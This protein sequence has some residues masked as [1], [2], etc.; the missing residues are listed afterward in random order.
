MK[1]D[2]QKPECGQCLRAGRSCRIIDG[3]FRPHSYSFLVSSSSSSSQRA[4]EASC[5]E[6]HFPGDPE[7]DNPQNRT[8][9]SHQT[10]EPVV[11][12]PSYRGQRARTDSPKSRHYQDEPVPEC[13]VSSTLEAH[14]VRTP[15]E[16]GTT[17]MVELP[18]PDTLEPLAVPGPPAILSA[19]IQNEPDVAIVAPIAHGFSS[20][21]NSTHEDNRRDRCEVAFFLR[22]FSEGPGQWM[23]VCCDHP[24]FS[25]QVPLLSPV[26]TL[27]RYSAVAL[28]A[29]QLGYM[30]SPESSIRQTQS[31]RLMMQAFAGSNLDFLWYGAK[32]YDKAIQI[33]SKLLSR[34]DQ[35]VCQ[36]SPRGSYQAGLPTPESNE[37]NLAAEYDNTGTTLQIIAACILCQYEDLSATMKAWSSHLDGTYRLLRSYL[38]ETATPP[39]ALPIP[40]PMKAMDAIY[41]FFAINDMLD[42]FVNK[43]RT[44]LESKDFS[45]WRKMGLPLDEDGKLMA[46]YVQEVHSESIFFKYLIWLMCQLV[47]SDLGNAVE[48]NAINE[49][50]DHWQ[51]ILPAIFSSAIHWPPFSETDDAQDP[52][53]IKITSHETWFPKDA[54]ALSMAFY[55]MARILL[56]IHRPLEA[57]RQKV[58][59]GADLLTTYHSLQHDLRGHAIEIISIARGAPNGTVR[60]YLIQPLYV[61]GRCLEDANERQELLSILRQIDEDLGVFTDYRQED[62]SLEWGIPYH[63]IEKNIVP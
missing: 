2:E 54:C 53:P 27:I 18:P 22:H 58:Q 44:R 37:F 30:K 60:K 20:L 61:A 31:H 39:A 48:W 51:A 24:Y 12:V 6:A 29:K 14:R 10:T 43:R 8:R 32:Y 7:E 4:H 16:A 55:N 50:F 25:E 41:W 19:H 36:M 35:S 21:Q 45:I 28:A 17:S 3:L 34:E 59:H 26:C 40:Q 62:L 15:Y 56:L 46:H 13:H 49:Q 47:N 42:A 9:I 63:P 33:F 5:L 38:H 57:L 11:Q 52:A 1:C 23:D